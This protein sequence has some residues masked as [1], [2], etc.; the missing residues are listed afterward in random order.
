M[1]WGM[2]TL[3]FLWRQIHRP[4]RYAWLAGILFV[5]LAAELAVGDRALELLESEG[6]QDRVIH[7]EQTEY[8]RL[9]LTRGKKPPHT[10]VLGGSPA[11]APLPGYMPRRWKD[12]LRL[13][14]DGN[15]QFSSLDEY[16]YHEAMVHPAM[17]LIDRPEKVLILGGGD[18]LA[19]TQVFLYPEV[20][21]V[22]L[23]DLDAR[24]VKL[25]RSHP[26]VRK[27]NQGSMD[28]PRMKVEI[29]DAFRYVGRCQERFDLIL[30]DLPDPHS[31][32]L[33]RLY[34][35]EF[36]A[37]LAGL[38]RSGGKLVSQSSSPYFARQAYWCIGRSMEAAGLH[39]AS[40]H[41][42]VPSFGDWGF[43]MASLDPID[44]GRLGLRVPT[45][46]LTEELLPSLF[47]FGRD[48]APVQVQPNT[49][50]NFK[51]FGYYDADDWDEY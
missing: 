10:A 29:D 21:E 8:Q 44:L 11:P 36:Y 14:L 1:C 42:E 18:G 31:P 4:M 49:L 3:L 51:L 47:L 23:V 6:Y 40:Y 35:K 48:V 24:M 34:S 33:S 26:E 16:R 5:G 41:L 45:R 27:A 39:A 38:L 12:D 22:V 19:A 13:F 28:D 37:R 15:L 17:G 20:R 25:A 50:T 9:V 43:H 46:F 30:V 7:R 2:L 32:T